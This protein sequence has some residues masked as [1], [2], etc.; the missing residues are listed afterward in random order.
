MIFQTFF[1]VVT[2]LIFVI[3][4]FVVLVNSHLEY[5]FFMINYTTII[6]II[7]II[8]IDTNSLAASNFNSI[9][10]YWQYKS[11]FLDKT[12]NLNKFESILSDLGSLFADP[13]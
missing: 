9:I 6:F 7:I 4:K 3:F 5:Q 8:I 2:L 13:H 12:L 11:I 10:S 1:L